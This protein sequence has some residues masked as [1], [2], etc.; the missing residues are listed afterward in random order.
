MARYRTLMF[1]MALVAAL[2]VRPA[3][4]SAKQH[5]HHGGVRQCQQRVADKIS[6]ERSRSRGS[7]FESSVQRTP[8]GSNA[9]TISGRGHVRTAQGKTRS[10]TYSC[11]YNLRNGNLSKVRYSIR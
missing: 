2:G 9:V 11:V 4:A 1:G 5:H 3:R 7:S 8:Y 10:F 6:A